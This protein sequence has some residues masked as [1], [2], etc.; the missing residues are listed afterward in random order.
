[1]KQTEQMLVPTRIKYLDCPGSV[2]M[3]HCCKYDALKKKQK[4]TKKKSIHQKCLKMKSVTSKQ[5][6]NN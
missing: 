4:Q 2:L 5:T 3:K 6:K 1:M